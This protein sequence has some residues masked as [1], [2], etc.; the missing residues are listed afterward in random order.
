MMDDP[1]VWI[2]V[3]LVTL[4]CVIQLHHEH[5]FLTLFEEGR[6]RSNCVFMT[7]NQSAYK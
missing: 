3:A 7:T 5:F 6:K 4:L 2:L 1:F